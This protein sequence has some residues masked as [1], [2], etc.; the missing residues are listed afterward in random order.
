V[1]RGSLSQLWARRPA[2]LRSQSSAA[3]AEAPAAA[4]YNASLGQPH[5]GLA[6]RGFPFESANPRPANELTP[7]GTWQPGHLAQI[8][9]RGVAQR[10]ICP[11]VLYLWP[12]A[13][14]S[15][16]IIECADRFPQLPGIRSSSPF[17]SPPR[18]CCRFCMFLYFSTPPTARA[19]SSSSSDVR[20]SSLTRNGSPPPG[21]VA[22]GHVNGRG[23]GAGRRRG[24]VHA[25]GP[26]RNRSKRR[27]SVRVCCQSSFLEC[28]PFR[29]PARLIILGFPVGP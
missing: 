16:V 21:R 22:A 25:V 7:R 23:C 13:R 1:T 10:V 19:L 5:R 14:L 20:G 15:V 3:P 2:G 29:H 24:P 9:S 6:P 18:R 11:L 4:L 27:S 28:H 12:T 17:M 26:A 8:S